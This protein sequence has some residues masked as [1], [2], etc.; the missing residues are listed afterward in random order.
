MHNAIHVF[1][2]GLTVL[3][4]IKE[5]KEVG[6]CVCIASCSGELSFC[7]TFVGKTIFHLFSSGL[8]FIFCCQV[9]Q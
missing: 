2:F 1:N 9:P 7:V 3:Q 6:V 4:V 8:E 5:Y